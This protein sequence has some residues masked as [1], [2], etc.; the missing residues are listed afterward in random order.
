[1]KNVNELRSLIREAFEINEKAPP[2]G[3]FQDLD[4]ERDPDKVGKE[5]EGADSKLKKNSIENHPLVSDVSDETKIKQKFSGIMKIIKDNNKSSDLESFNKSLTDLNEKILELSKK[6]KSQLKMGN[7][8]SSDKNSFIS[9]L[10]EVKQLLKINS[11]NSL[12]NKEVKNWYM[13]NSL[14]K[15]SF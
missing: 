12:K 6:M 4:L 2:G 15:K 13:I 1:M 14:D 9:N 7:I 8:I 5:K 3:Y 11:P 10:K